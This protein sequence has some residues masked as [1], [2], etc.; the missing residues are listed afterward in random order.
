MSNPLLAIPLLLAIGLVWWG[1]GWIFPRIML[2]QPP[3]TTTNNNNN[4]NNNNENTNNNYFRPLLAAYICLFVGITYVLADQLHQSLSKYDIKAALFILMWYPLAMQFLR[5]CHLLVVGPD[6]FARE[7]GL[8]RQLHVKHLR[9]FIRVTPTIIFRN[10]KEKEDG[11]DNNNTNHYETTKK[12]ND[13]YDYQKESSSSSSSFQ[14]APPTLNPT[15]NQFRIILM[16]LLWIV[17]ICGAVLVFRMGDWL[18]DWMQRVLRVYIMGLSTSII[19][20]IYECPL[21]YF[22]LLPPGVTLLPLYDRPYLTKAP[23]ELWR[24]WSVTA[25]FHLRKAFY[26]PIL[27]GL[28]QQRRR[29]RRRDGG[30]KHGDG[31]MMMMVA[32][33]LAAAAPF[34]VNCVMHIYWW[35]M[36]VKGKIDHVYWILLFVYPL[37]SMAVEDIMGRFV[38][39]TRRATTWPHHVANLALLWGGFYMVGEFMAH[40]HALNSDLTA[41]CRANLLLPPKH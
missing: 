3:P 39:G 16:D 25:G 40:A 21:V 41:V 28:K 23:R 32:S 18:P 31:S 1:Q 13:D 19:R 30:G 15:T 4:N 29:R 10:N 22:R 38:F 36:G 9:L 34:F 14:K 7:F 20:L 24:R 26:E 17:V 33:I 35:S 5:Y 11:D 12:K 6:K 2:F 27:D 8:H 37:L